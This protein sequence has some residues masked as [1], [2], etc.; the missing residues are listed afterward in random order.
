MAPFFNGE[1]GAENM[2]DQI[3]QLSDAENNLIREYANIL[4]EVRVRITGFSTIVKGTSSLPSWLTAELLYLQ[5][6]LLCELVAVGC[7]VAHGDMGKEEVQQLGKRH[8]PGLILKKLEE[9]HPQ[10]FPRPISVTS[11]E[12]VHH[13]EHAKSDFLTKEEFL[14]LYA[15]CH[16]HL[17]RGN[18]SQIFSQI[19]PKK[20][21]RI[22][23][24]LH[25]A[26]Q[27]LALLNCHH[28]ASFIE[29]KNL[30]CFLAHEQ[31]GGDA[32]VVAALA[33][34]N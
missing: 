9:L 16:R 24:A 29:G 10:F 27:L 14:R 19:N 33:A 32:L 8:E 6:R 26:A 28:I 5:L 34:Q 13:I 18:L 15:E 4:N 21:P 11:G 25:W 7:L 3:H 2:N 12:N 31:V 30:I 20:P 22:E 17:H 23:D 1:H